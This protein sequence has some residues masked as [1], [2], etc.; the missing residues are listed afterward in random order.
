MTD[1]QGYITMYKF[2]FH[3]LKSNQDQFDQFDY[4]FP[5]LLS[6]MIIL[7]DGM[8]A[9]SAQWSDWKD[10]VSEGNTTEEAAF[11]AMMCFLDDYRKRGEMPG[12]DITRVIKIINS[13]PETTREKWLECVQEALVE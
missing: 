5:G 2:L 8:P 9:D 12:G 13:S 11:E 4:E 10:C 3:L 7:E 6:D 1:K